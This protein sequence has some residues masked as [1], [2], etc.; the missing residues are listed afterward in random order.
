MANYLKSKIEPHFRYSTPAQN[1][2]VAHEFI[3]SMSNSRQSVRG[4]G[5][6]LEAIDG[7]MDSMRDGFF[8]RA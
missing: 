3:L 5:G 8:S 7:I 6:H 2:R 1:G 4:S